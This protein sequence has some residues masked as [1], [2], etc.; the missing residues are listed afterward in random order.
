[1]AMTLKPPSASWVVE[2]CEAHLRELRAEGQQFA[3]DCRIYADPR[4]H[5]GHCGKPLLE[6]CCEFGD[7]WLKAFRETIFG[8]W[9]VEPTEPAP[10]EEQHREALYSRVVDRWNAKHRGH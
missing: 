7:K 3:S 8:R 2:S 10:Y 1:M 4:L 6:G 5:C 9:E